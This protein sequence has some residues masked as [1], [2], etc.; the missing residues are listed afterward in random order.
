M[1]Y[2]IGSITN[3]NIQLLY[4]YRILREPSDNLTAICRDGR[5]QTVDTLVWKESNRVVDGYDTVYEATL[6]GI[7]VESPFIPFLEF[8]P[9]ENSDWKW[10][11]DF[12]DA[13][14]T[15]NQIILYSTTNYLEVLPIDVYQCY[16]LRHIDKLLTDLLND[17]ER[18]SHDYD[19][20]E[21]EIRNFR[22]SGRYL[23]RPS[24]LI[25]NLVKIEN[26]AEG[27]D[28]VD[29]LYQVMTAE[30]NR[31]FVNLS[32]DNLNHLEH[33]FNESVEFRFIN[34]DHYVLDSFIAPVILVS[35]NGSI[36]LKNLKGQ[37][38]VTNWS[39]SITVIDCPEVHLT[40]I[41]A[42]YICRLNVLQISKGSTVYLENQVHT[43]KELRM[44]A[45]S[46]CRHWRA[47]VKNL[48]YVG[49]GCTYWCCAQV[50]TPG[51]AQ[52]P[53]YTDASNTVFDFNLRDILG[54][55]VSDFDNMM[56][57]GQKNLTPRLGN[58]DAE[59][60]PGMYVSNW[61]A[62]YNS[63]VPVNPGG[64]PGPG[65]LSETT[66]EGL[67]C[68]VW[69]PESHENVG[70]ILCV[71][72][73]QGG[74]AEATVNFG[75]W[76]A[77]EKVRPRAACLFLQRPSAGALPSRNSILQKIQ[78]LQTQCNLGTDL[79]YFGF[80]AGANAYPAISTWTT[81]K[82]AV[83]IDCN[84]ASACN[85]STAGLEKL[86]VVQGAMTVGWAYEKYR[87]VVPE[88]VSYDYHGAYSHASV[89]YWT[90]SDTE[91]TYQEIITGH[92][93]YQRLPDNPPNGLV[94][95]CGG[96]ALPGGDGA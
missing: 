25:P 40:A 53:E 57:V 45:N 51:R 15:D 10:I 32:Q 83:L 39:G 42:A 82:G 85:F 54:S 86:M 43:I 76:M 8:H 69:M 38:L 36:V 11:S 29:S 65:E 47:N 62:K 21:N 55:F 77:V 63:Y 72:G 16:S 9:Q 33:I 5:S 66:I 1:F 50:S 96:S 19:Q 59:P 73:V 75:A 89:N 4:E 49:P 24:G 20:L 61:K 68:W 93:A 90:P 81:F 28:L 80:S 92:A 84:V 95:L 37:V 31:L 22:S 87:G 30:S 64:N 14:V 2:D 34:R 52:L 67:T 74:V 94:W 70:L 7:S 60:Q 48:A 44:H 26:S 91:Q 58:C 71:P 23:K 27:S 35:G 46:L 41:N 88:F 12:I 17:L 56:I 3:R 18:T 78:E 13:E 6:D 79:W